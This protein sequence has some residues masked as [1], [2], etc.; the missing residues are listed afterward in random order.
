M[1]IQGTDEWKELR[2]GKVTASRI[3]DVIAKT[4]TGYS[5][6]RENYLTEL[7]I[8]RFGVLAESF[9]NSAMVHGTE[10]EPYARHAYEVKNNV[11]VSEIDFVPHPTIAMAGAS[12]DGLIDDGLLEIKCPDSKTHFNYLIANVVPEQY[13]P[14][15]AFQMACTGHNW[16]DFVSFDNRVPDGLEYFEIRYMRDDDYI[17]MIEDE[18]IKLLKEVDAK[19]NQLNQYL[20]KKAA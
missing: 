3:K 8:E 19:Y 10:C 14:Q 20:L 18:V 1:I 9:T 2:R 15:M 17:L 16:C 4:K 5:A 6:S 7:V 11:M 13:K 12:P